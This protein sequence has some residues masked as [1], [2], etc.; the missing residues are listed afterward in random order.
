M[1]LSIPP[2]QNQPTVKLGPN[3]E[4]VLRV[5][6]ELVDMA[7]YWIDKEAR[8]F[9]PMDD[10]EQAL[11]IPDIELARIMSTAL[12][13]AQSYCG[14]D[15]DYYTSLMELKAW[16]RTRERAMPR[17]MERGLSQFIGV[18][19]SL[20]ESIKGGFIVV[21]EK[22]SA[23][24]ADIVRTICK[25]FHLAARTINAKFSMNDEYDVQDLLHAV[26]RVNLLHHHSV[27]V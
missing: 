15:S 17:P 26:L 1:A 11:S 3:A 20:Q 23:D 14:S 10:D 13:L 8:G 19:Q 18:I 25:R 24:D 21:N 12:H 5:M 7:D 2:P 6:K 4:R 16:F 27:Y 9:D 22:R